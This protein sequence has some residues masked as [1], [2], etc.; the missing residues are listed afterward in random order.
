MSLK[1]FF[2]CVLT[3]YVRAFLVFHFVYQL[4]QAFSVQYRSSAYAFTIIIIQ[5]LLLF[6]VLLLNLSLQIQWLQNKLP[7]RGLAIAKAKGY[8]GSRLQYS[9]RPCA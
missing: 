8:M 4:L 2:F 3:T 7:D 5:I 9:L 6:Q 1:Q